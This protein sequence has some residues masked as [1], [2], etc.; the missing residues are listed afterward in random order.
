MQNPGHA[1]HPPVTRRG[2]GV[3]RVSAKQTWGHAR[4]G[5]S[6][7]RQLPQRLLS[8]LRVTNSDAA[9]DYLCQNV[10]VAS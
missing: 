4:H 10:G 6:H 7:P 5:T 1:A 2:L 8:R 3:R 9:L